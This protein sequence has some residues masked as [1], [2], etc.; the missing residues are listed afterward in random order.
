VANAERTR[1]NAP[2]GCR[3]Y[4]WPFPLQNHYVNC[5]CLIGDIRFVEGYNCCISQNDLDNTITINACLGGG[6]GQPCSEVAIFADEEAPQGKSTLSGSLK[7]SEVIK[8]INGVGQRFYE[9]LGGP[10]VTVT[11]YPDVNKI[12]VDVN[13]HTLAVCGQFGDQLV[14]SSSSLN[15]DPCDCGPETA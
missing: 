1:A 5:E 2:Q 7:C 11:P 15:P 3:E 6:K 4:C 14:Y 13:L 12:V 10:G 8:S 9:I